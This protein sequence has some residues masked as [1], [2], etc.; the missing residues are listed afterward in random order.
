MQLV[1]ASKFANPF[2]SKHKGKSLAGTIANHDSDHI[3][4]VNAR[5]GTEDIDLVNS[6]E[7]INLLQDR[8]DL[9]LTE[10]HLRLL[11]EL[12]FMNQSS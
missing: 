1:K 9:G 7:S 3:D 5:C 6:G 4:V 11:A 8:E 10:E 12:E 2:V